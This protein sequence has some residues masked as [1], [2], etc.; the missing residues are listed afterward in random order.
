M[1][2]STFTSF[3]SS[4][5]VCFYIDFLLQWKDLRKLDGDRS[6]DYSYVILAV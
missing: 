6:Y 3:Y 2:T 1:T 5:G 4:T